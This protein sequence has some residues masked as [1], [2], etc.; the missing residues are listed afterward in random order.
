[1]QWNAP[2]ACGFQFSCVQ[3]FI[4][5]HLGISCACAPCQYPCMLALGHT[6]AHTYT[7]HQA[8]G[9][10][11][12]CSLKGKVNSC[13]CD[14]WSSHDIPSPNI[15]DSFGHNGE[16]AERGPFTAWTRRQSFSLQPGWARFFQNAFPVIMWEV[17]SFSLVCIPY[18][19][20][21]FA[22]KQAS[23]AN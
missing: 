20:P 7:Q 19:S 2:L 1:M 14:S 3:L 17:M 12:L 18:N 4:F 8:A 22:T 15:G 6:L 23:R 21:P 10:R 16:S 11:Q 5:L 13:A 9:Q